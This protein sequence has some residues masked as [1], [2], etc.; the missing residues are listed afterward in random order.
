[1]LKYIPLLKDLAD[2]VQATAVFLGVVVGGLWTYLLFVRKRLAYPRVNLELKVY[3]SILTE[4][5]RLVHVVISIKKPA[6]C[7]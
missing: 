1:M 6:T 3:D 4:S 2:F 5:T 7:C